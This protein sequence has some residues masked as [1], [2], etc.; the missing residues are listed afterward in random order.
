[1]PQVII[2]PSF[3]KDAAKK[4]WRDT[5]DKEVPFTVSPYVDALSREHLDALMEMHP[6]GTARF[7]GATRNHDKRMRSLATGDVVLFTGGKLIRAV[8]E[9]GVSLQNAVFG[10]SMWSRHPINGSYNNIYS[11]L[12]FQQLIGVGYQEVWKLPG[13]NEGDNFMGL[14]FLKPD[15]GEMVLEGL[16]IRTVTAAQAE[17]ADEQRLVERLTER[18]GRVVAAEAVK[19]KSTSYNRQAG[20]ALVNRAEALLLELY[21]AS[22]PSS[23]RT[24]L[25]IPYGVADFYEAGPEGA[26][27]VEAKS[28]N[29]HHHVRQALAQLL[30]YVLH[31]PAPVAKLGALFP[32]QPQGHSVQLLHRYGIDCIYLQEDGSFGTIGAPDAARRH[33]MAVWTRP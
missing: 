25:R 1:M 21:R 24:T 23:S 28:R 10:D 8:G 27:I 14:R 4:H 32:G 16:N 3:G 26:E 7:W 6:G 31:S 19:T 13:F 2:Q 15:A 5:L 20:T 22:L 18:L 29:S 12:S 30:D 11:L 33:M 17:A 9:V